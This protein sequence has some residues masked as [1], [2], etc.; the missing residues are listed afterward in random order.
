MP[1]NAGTALMSKNLDINIDNFQEV[2]DAVENNKIDLLIV[3]PEKPLVNGIVDF[4]NDTDVK[5]FGPNKAASQLEGSKIFTK[6][7]CEKY[8]IPTAKFGIFQN[9]NETIKFI[10]KTN[11]PIVIKADGLAAGKG[12]YICENK[13]EAHNAVGEIFRGK[14][15]FA[16]NILVEEFLDGEEMSFFVLTDGV[17]IKCFETA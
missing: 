6:K 13:D 8:K 1:G 17:S 9:S 4:L 16:K 11:L 12:V 15:G 3:G 10:N 14:F 5:I 2:K 7:L